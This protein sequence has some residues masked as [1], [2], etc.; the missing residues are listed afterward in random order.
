M[1]K[2]GSFWTNSIIEN[3]AWESGVIFL[4]RSGIG[5]GGGGRDRFWILVLHEDNRG[6]FIFEIRDFSVQASCTYSRSAKLQLLKG[7][8][9]ALVKHRSLV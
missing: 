8:H 3:F 6:S 4:L 5:R 1:N 2:F 9:M 7:Q